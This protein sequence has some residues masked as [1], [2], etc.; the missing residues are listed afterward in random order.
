M[1]VQSEIT[2]NMFI[3]WYSDSQCNNFDYDISGLF[4]GPNWFYMLW[5]VV[6][7]F[8]IFRIVLTAYFCIP[9]TNG[10]PTIIWLYPVFSKFNDSPVSDI[11]VDRTVRVRDGPESAQGDK[12]PKLSSKQMHFGFKVYSYTAQYMFVFL[13]INSSFS[14]IFPQKKGLL[15]SVWSKPCWWST[16]GTWTTY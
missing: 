2:L 13:A 1:F 4:L 16:F 11:G 6:V 3:D 8:T 14:N 15:H 9:T 7:N 12:C 5:G 10:I